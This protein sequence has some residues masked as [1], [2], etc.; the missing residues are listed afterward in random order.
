MEK[1]AD[2]FGQSFFSWDGG[3]NLRIKAFLSANDSEP[4]ATFKRRFIEG[5]G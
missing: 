3:N 1:R 5:K 2:V 4:E